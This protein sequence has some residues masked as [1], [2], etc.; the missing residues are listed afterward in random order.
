MLGVKPLEPMLRQHGKSI[1][2]VTLVYSVTCAGEKA[3]SASLEAV[4]AE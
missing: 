1:V 3:L 4:N 2:P